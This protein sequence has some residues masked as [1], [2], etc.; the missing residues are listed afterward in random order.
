MIGPPTALDYLTPEVARMAHPLIWDLMS[1]EYD[2][3]KDP[4]WSALFQVA[5]ALESVLRIAGEKR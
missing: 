5:L 4:E 2:P 3:E 1:A